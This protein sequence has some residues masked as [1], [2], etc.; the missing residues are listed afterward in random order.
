MSDF[1]NY[2]DE[3]QGDNYNSYQEDPAKRTYSPYDTPEPNRPVRKK[4][5]GNFIGK[6]AKAICLGLTFGLAAGAAFIGVNQV[7]GNLLGSSQPQNAG[8]QVNIVKTSETDVQTIN[9][10]DVS[11]IVE[12]SMP[13]IVAVNTQVVTTQYFFG[14]SYSQEGSGAGSGFLISE[15]NGTL[16]VLTNYHVIEGSTGISVTFN[17]GSS[18]EASVRGYD[19]AADIA[20]LTVDYKSLCNE[21]KSDI[22]I[23]VMGDSDAL[24]VGQGA[25]AIGYALGYGQSVTTGAISAIDREVK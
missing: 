19:E 21:T 11:D 20:V 18:A 7:A 25:I 8:V 16:Y 22:A 23:A 2:H 9:A 14:Q 1:Y 12:Q 4:K 6:L 10:T 13:S 24:K 5:K 17:D 3:Q 15:S